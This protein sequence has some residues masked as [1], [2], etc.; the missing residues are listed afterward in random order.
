[1]TVPG[2][3]HK[4]VGNGEQDD[5]AQGFLL[6]PTKGF[7]RF[8]ELPMVQVNEAVSSRVRRINLCRQ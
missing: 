8:S 5:C 7:G 6:Y 2:K 1:V 3:R 4:D